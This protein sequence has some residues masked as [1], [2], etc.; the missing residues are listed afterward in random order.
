VPV[1]VVICGEPA[2]L[3]ATD[4]VAVKLATEAGE[5]VTEIAQLAPAASDSPQLLVWA[6]STESVPVTVIPLM[7]SPALPVFVR[8]AVCAALVAPET[9]VKVSV[10]GVSE[11][12]GAGAAEKLAVTLCGALMVTVV[13]ALEALATLPVQPLKTKP[14]LGVAVRATAVPAA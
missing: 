5:K 6:K 2:A 9:A 12:A 4:S 3:S 13:E 1:S 8:V 14:E 7:A 11:A 10:L